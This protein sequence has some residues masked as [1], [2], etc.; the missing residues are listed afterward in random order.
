MEKEQRPPRP[1]H[2]TNVVQDELP[3]PPEPPQFTDFI[4]KEEDTNEATT[5][6]EPSPPIVEADANEEE[7][8]GSRHSTPE[9]RCVVFII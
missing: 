5:E 8:G 2:R 7:L 1:K 9:E 6:N 4:E 3:P